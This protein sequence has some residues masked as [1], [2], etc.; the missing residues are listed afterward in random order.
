MLDALPVDVGPRYFP[1]VAAGAFV[2]WLAGRA[3]AKWLWRGEMPSYIWA[4]YCALGWAAGTGLLSAIYD[5]NRP[6]EPGGGLSDVEY[7]FALV[8]CG[9]VA[10]LAS[11]AQQAGVLRGHGVDSGWWIVAS[12][13]ATSIGWSIWAILAL[14]MT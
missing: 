12:T 1:A 3:Q 14:T 2:G 5:L 13:C 11:G 6:A 10:G 9:A 8:I 4:S 7:A